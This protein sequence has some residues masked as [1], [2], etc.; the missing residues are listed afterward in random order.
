MKTDI[1]ALPKSQ[2]ARLKG[3]TGIRSSAGN[4]F[5]A[6]PLRQMKGHACNKASITV[7]FLNV[8][9]VFNN[10]DREE[11]HQTKGARQVMTTRNAI[12]CAVILAL[13]IVGGISFYAQW[14]LKRFNASLPTPPVAVQEK[15]NT[16]T[17]PQ[18]PTKGAEHLAARPE[19]S[20]VPNDGP[21]GLPEITGVFSA[22]TDIGETEGVPW[23][24]TPLEAGHLEAERVSPF[25]FGPYPDVPPDFP[26]QVPWNRSEEGMARF[27]EDIRIQFEL[28]ARVLIK[29][30]NQGHTNLDGGTFENGLV[31]P[32]YPGT[33]YLRYEDNWE[34]VENGAIH[35]VDSEILVGSGVSAAEEAQ[36]LK[37]ETPPGIRIL[38]F[39]DGIEPY[40]FLDLP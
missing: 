30:W 10:S 4:R 19:T 32:L 26:L 13:A 2:I 33:V 34:E 40:T 31:L 17:E 7:K 18:H 39:S 11:H 27:N 12:V 29:L 38:D 35:A 22:E 36:I 20:A 9:F 23:L 14:E 16:D 6:E 21:E 28:M 37:G 15:E 8:L 24:D 25:G 5:L 1:V 3:T